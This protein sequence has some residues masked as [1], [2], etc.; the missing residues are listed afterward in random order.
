MAWFGFR[1]RGGRGTRRPNALQLP[2]STKPA[3]AR[4][5]LCDHDTVTW[6]KFVLSLLAFE[7][8]LIGTQRM[9]LSEVSGPTTVAFSTFFLVMMKPWNYGARRFT[10]LAG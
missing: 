2:R 10:D 1:P 4:P 3:R 8:F 9:V 5:V 7:A 6:Q